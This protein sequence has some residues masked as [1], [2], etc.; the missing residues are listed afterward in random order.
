MVLKWSI[1]S[2]CGYIILLL[3]SLDF[4][5]VFDIEVYLTRYFMIYIYIWQ[6]PKAKSI[7]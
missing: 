1:L 5:V 2:A 4:G 7:I 3:I 6:T